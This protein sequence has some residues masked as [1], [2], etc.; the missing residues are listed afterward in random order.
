MS[1]DRDIISLFQKYYSAFEEYPFSYLNINVSKNFSD[2]SDKIAGYYENFLEAK[3]RESVLLTDLKEIKE[4]LDNSDEDEIF[5]VHKIFMNELNDEF[6]EAFEKLEQKV[7]DLIYNREYNHIESSILWNFVKSYPINKCEKKYLEQVLRPDSVTYSSS[8]FKYLYDGID[9]KLFVCA[10]S[11]NLL[12]EIIAGFNDSL[13]Y[14]NYSSASR[15]AG[16]GYLANK[17]E[18]FVW[19]LIHLSNFLRSNS[20]E[21][22]ELNKQKAQLL[23]FIDKKRTSNK[24]LK[25]YLLLLPQVNSLYQNYGFASLIKYGLNITK[26]SAK[27]LVSTILKKYLYE[28][29]FLD[30]KE[31][32]VR[33]I[34]SRVPTPAKL[35]IVD[36]G[37]ALDERLIFDELSITYTLPIAKFNEYV[38]RKDLFLNSFYVRGKKV[39][40]LK[41]PFANLELKFNIKQLN[42]I[43]EHNK[44]SLI[45]L[46]ELAQQDKRL[47]LNESVVRQEN[48]EPYNSFFDDLKLVEIL[49]QETNDF[50]VLKD[51]LESVDLLT[52]DPNLNK[53]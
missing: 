4:Y 17:D 43:V 23:D 29:S 11:P 22:Q 40:G 52:N 14:L 48:I 2:F 33:L 47:S 25:N 30:E 42:E 10:E 46:K 18:F 50:R 13:F 35:L 34:P 19:S 6:L 28:K 8:G 44:K 36:Y 31:L 20:F 38:R 26:N 45:K 15:D 49:I 9:K 21:F 24:Q 7:E 16:T 3:S 27:K 37:N 41:D 53:K 51:F 12:F 1:L 32:G 39:S 5:D